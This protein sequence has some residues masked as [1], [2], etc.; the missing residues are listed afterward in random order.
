MF[1]TF[2]KK[3]SNLPEY[4]REE[5]IYIVAIDHRVLVYP[6]VAAAVFLGSE[7]YLFTIK[8]SLC[9]RNAMKTTKFSQ[10]TLN[11]QKKFLGAIYI[12]VDSLGEIDF[13]PKTFRQQFSS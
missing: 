5:S 3:L 2:L 10:V 9:M 13:K 11:L 6:T 1:Q 7:A 8:I 4:V 12:Q